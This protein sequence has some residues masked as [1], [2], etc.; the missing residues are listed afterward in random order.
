[1]VG[2][3]AL[4][5]DY[6]LSGKSISLRQ[7]TSNLSSTSQVITTST[8]T[9]TTAQATSST[10]SASS[11]EL[12]SLEGDL[13][14]GWD[15]N[16]IK[17]EG[18]KPLSNEGMFLGFNVGTI[19]QDF[20]GTTSDSS[21]HWEIN[22]IPVGD[23]L[24]YADANPFS[25]TGTQFRYM[26]QSNKDFAPI[27][28]SVPTAGGNYNA[29]NLGGY[30]LSSTESQKMNFECSNGFLTLPFPKGTPIKINAYVD[31]GNGRNYLNQSCGIAGSTGTL[32]AMP[33][34]TPI[35]AAV[36]GKLVS[37]EEIGSN[38]STV[39][40]SHE[41]FSRFEA[42]FTAYDYL[43]EVEVSLDQE[44][45]RGQ[46]LGSSGKKKNDVEPSLLF[47][48]TRATECGPEILDPYASSW[49]NSP[50]SCSEV[51]DLWDL[52]YWTKKNDPQ[53]SV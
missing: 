26:C 23:Y 4:G 9:S 36:P 8:P 33:T 13:Y 31:E 18:M 22:D 7:I 20:R 46:R 19:F 14:V 35:V 11:R 50:S 41:E 48:L 29:G 38:G 6:L 32:F 47:E 52:G 53:F 44:V 5:L 39:V 16:G 43:S 24:L 42:I 30:K 51:Q 49:N 37:I 28:G 21:G 27:G 40:I 1:V 12:V 17:Q 45:Y 2:G 3:S 25:G 34:G 10:S 15:G